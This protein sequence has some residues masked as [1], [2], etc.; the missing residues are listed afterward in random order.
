M[1]EQPK[2]TK[3]QRELL[4]WLIAS[5]R[6]YHEV[7]E[8]NG[9]PERACEFSGGS[10]IAYYQER[11]TVELRAR[12]HDWTPRGGYADHGWRRVGG[13]QLRRL[14][15]KGMLVRTGIVW[16]TPQYQLTK[17]GRA[18]ADGGA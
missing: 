4:D 16:G 5:E 2:L 3:A 15:D 10:L 1:T 18:H 7:R 12:G 8:E 11:A 6:R 17:A 9:Y 13:L 14:A